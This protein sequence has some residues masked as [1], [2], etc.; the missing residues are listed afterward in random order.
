MYD[1]IYIIVTLPNPLLIPKAFGKEGARG[2]YGNCSLSYALI[3]NI[4]R[5]H[6]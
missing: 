3:S 4:R 1:D 2:S 5:F 6:G